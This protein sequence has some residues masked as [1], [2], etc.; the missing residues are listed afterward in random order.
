M[1]LSDLLASILGHFRKP[2]MSISLKDYLTASGKYPERENHPELT[3]ELKKNAE[4]FLKTLNAFLA[5]IG[6]TNVKV[7]SGFRPSAVNASTPGSAKKSLHMICLACDIE[8]SDGS[9]DNLVDSRDDLLKK[10][11]LWQ[12]SPAATKGWLHLDNK[13]RGKRPKNQFIP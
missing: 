12:E 4:S 5:E 13:D 8:D 6:L 1:T 7:S 2:K 11:G 3:P 10:H 9:K